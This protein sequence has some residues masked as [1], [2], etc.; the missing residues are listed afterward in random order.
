MLTGRSLL[1]C[2]VCPF[3]TIVK[4]YLQRTGALSCIYLIFQDDVVLVTLTGSNAELRPVH[5]A[6]VCDKSECPAAAALHAHKLLTLAR[7]YLRSFD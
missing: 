3:N 1:E 5:L 6:L 2:T 7:A 4:D